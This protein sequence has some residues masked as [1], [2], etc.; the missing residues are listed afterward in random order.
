MPNECRSPA[1]GFQYSK[2]EEDLMSDGA[3]TTRN[4]GGRIT[5]SM[6]MINL[7]DTGL[8]NSDVENPQ[9][10]YAMLFRH[11]PSFRRGERSL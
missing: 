2:N 8:P 5:F 7:S 11:A 9:R 3:L 4:V 1:S 6:S 10:F